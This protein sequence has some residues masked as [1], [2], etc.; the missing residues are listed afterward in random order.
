MRLM[1][2]VRLRVKDLD[3]ELRQITLRD[4]KGAKDRVTMLPDTLLA[5]WRGIY[6]GRCCIR[7]TCQRA[8]ARFIYPM[9]WR[10]ST[11]TRRVNGPGNTYF[12]RDRFLPIRA[13]GGVAGTM[14]TRRH[15]SVP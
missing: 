15:C 5:R 6:A 11:Q 12:Q 7:R 2:C 9:R 10:E 3:F 1:E 8:S 4:G 14:W 13:P